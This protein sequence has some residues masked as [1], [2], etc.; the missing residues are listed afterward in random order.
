SARARLDQAEREATRALGQL[1]LW[2]GPLDAVAALAV[3]STETVDRFE[4]ELAELDAELARL[5]TARRAALDEAADAESSLEKLRQSAGV[6]PTEDDLVGARARR[7][8]IWRL[9]RRA[10]EPAHPPTSEEIRAVLA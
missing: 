8:R 1:P 7:D 5:R 4:A 9:V 3:P 6:L 2:T 10:G